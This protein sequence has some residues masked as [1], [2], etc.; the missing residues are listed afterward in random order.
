MSSGSEKEC[1]HKWVLIDVRKNK[2]PKDFPWY[3]NWIAT[4]ICE[5]CGKVKEV[6]GHQ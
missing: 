6:E 1:D 4:F 3:W 2:N 5:Y